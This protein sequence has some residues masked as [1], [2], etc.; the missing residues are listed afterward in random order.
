MENSLKQRIIGAVVLIALGIIFLPAILKDKVN[1]GTFESKIP[2]QPEELAKYRVDTQKIDELVAKQKADEKQEFNEIESAGSNNKIKTEPL[3]DQE[4]QSENSKPLTESSA[5]KTKQSED[6]DSNIGNKED[7]D[8]SDLKQ[9]NTRISEKYQDA[10]WV[11]QVA[12]FSKQSNARKMVDRL[13]ENNYKAYR[14]K[15]LSG[16]RAVFRV[17]VGPYIEKK[18]AQNALSQVSILSE[19]SAIIKPFDPIKH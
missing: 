7:T 14:R 12:S 4:E 1:S 3:S 10:A 11:I 5:R 2:A 17:F 13:K 18:T 15:V 9:K 16:D 19:S 6:S 8:Q